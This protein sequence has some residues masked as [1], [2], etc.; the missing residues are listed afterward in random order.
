MKKELYLSILLLTLMP[1]ASVFAQVQMGESAE[2]GGLMGDPA[3]NT[4]QSAF[5][6]EDEPVTQQQGT[7]KDKR[8]LNSEDKNY[9]Y[10]GGKNFINRPQEKF[11]E[12]P[13]SYFGYDFFV[14]AP[15]TFAPE[16]N[17]PVPPDYILG[18]NDEIEMIT[19]GSKNSTYQLKVNR[20]GVVFFPGFGPVSVAGLTFEDA[21]ETLEV[22]VQNQMLGTRINLS[23]GKL[24]SMDIFVLG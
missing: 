6:E 12:E 4:R 14:D 9:G 21:R 19:Y 22:I 17:I 8:R 24:R 11:F 23:M 16:I 5:S 15:T 7:P 1:S 18:P 20:D 13:L 10:T 3:A 2:E